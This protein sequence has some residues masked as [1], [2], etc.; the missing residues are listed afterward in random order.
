MRTWPQ[1]HGERIRGETRLNADGTL[2]ISSWPRP[3]HDGIATRALTLM[4]WLRLPSLELATH[5]AATQPAAGGSAL[6]AAALAGALL[7]HLGGGPG[8]ALLHAVRRRGGAG[9]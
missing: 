5:K 2:D 6:H 8:P 3:Q 7:R 9:R 4:R 1:A